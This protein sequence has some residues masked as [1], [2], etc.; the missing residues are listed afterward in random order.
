MFNIF[1]RIRDLED[2]KGQTR[3]DLFEKMRELES[4]LATKMVDQKD[5]LE[6]KI[7]EGWNK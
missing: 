2:E 7:K 3:A 4:K 1:K 5:Y 6:E